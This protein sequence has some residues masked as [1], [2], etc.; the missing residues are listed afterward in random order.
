MQ[1]A[2]QSKRIMIRSSSSRATF[3]LLLRVSLEYSF[4]G[5]AV[6]AEKIT[7]NVKRGAA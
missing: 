3:I 1:A 2:I 5:R 4:Q 6:I 7:E